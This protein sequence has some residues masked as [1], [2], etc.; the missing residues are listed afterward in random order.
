MELLL[1]LTLPDALFAELQT[2]SR[3][4]GTTPARFAAEALEATLADR[5]LSGVT[6]GRCGPRVLDVPED[7]EAV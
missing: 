2:A 3:T 5:R 4:C 1:S 6:T 7:C